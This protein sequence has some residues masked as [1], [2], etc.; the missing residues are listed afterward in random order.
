MRKTLVGWFGLIM[1]VGVLIPLTAAAGARDGINLGAGFTLSPFV[2]GSATYDSNV[3]L[4]PAGQETND[5]YYGVVGGASLLKSTDDL[6]IN[7]RGWYRIRR[8]DEATSL[9]DETWQESLDIVWGNVEDLQIKINQRYS[10]VS[11]YEFSQAEIG[12]QGGENLTLRLIE[13]RTRRTHRQLN[14]IGG[15]LAHQTD[16]LLAQVGGGHAEVTFDNDALLEWSETEGNIDLGYE[17]SD[18]SS[19]LVAG[20]YGE[21]DTDNA[22]QNA[23]FTKVRVG[24]RSQ[25]TDKL[26]FSAGVGFETYRAEDAE[27]SSEGLD[28]DLFHY[29]LA[30]AWAITR[31]LSLQAFGRNEM[32]PT[33]AFDQ[34]TK[35]IDQ[36]S[37]G[38]LWNFTQNWQ[39]T[40]GGSFRRDDYTRTINDIHAREE[41]G[42]VQWKLGYT[43]RDK[44]VNVVLNVRYEEFESNIQDD[45]DQLRVSLLANLT[46]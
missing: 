18:K 5:I 30:A 23:N 38:A 46:Y 8:Y 13:G 17:V 33:S 19:L 28:A 16:K 42:G 3:H 11:D 22:L 25:R 21:H 29:D 27:G 40:L 31:K 10:D 15:S 45:Y 44:V 14:D 4:D 41:I 9:D 12:S 26:S 24:M 1:F 37:L 20:S 34:N 7:L 36:F 32:L 6:T 39:T 35:Q 2:E 43:P